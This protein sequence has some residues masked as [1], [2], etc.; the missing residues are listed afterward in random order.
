MLLAASHGHR[1]SLVKAGDGLVGFDK[2]WGRKWKEGWKKRKGEEEERGREE[3]YLGVAVVSV[4]GVTTRN[5]DFQRSP[6]FK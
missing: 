2:G 3:A 4:D 5:P 6:F 1:Q